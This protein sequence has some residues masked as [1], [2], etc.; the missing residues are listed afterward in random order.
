MVGA[1]D[2]TK[3][4]VGPGR[5]WLNVCA[6]APYTRLLINANGEPQQPAWAL[7][8]PWSAGQMIVDSNGN[9]QECVA[10][11]VGAGS[12][13]TWKTDLYGE[14]ADGGATWRCVALAP[15]YQFVGASEGAATASLSPK[16][17]GIPA[18][19]AGAPIDAYMQSEIEAIEIELK[20]SDLQKM[21]M[22]ITHGSYATGT[23]AGLPSGAQTYEEISFGGILTVPKPSVV[24]ISP[25]RDVI[26]KYVVIQL[27]R[28]F[29][30]DEIKLPYTRTKETMYK[31]KF[32]GLWDDFRPVG[33]KVGKIY[34]QL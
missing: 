32:E 10:T 3:I 12:A 27:Y 33:D 26:S 22:V 11:G 18:D 8:A 7:N 14:V 9:V 30:A 23:D 4:H 19:Q 31:V 15:V 1:I 34:R 20:E 16:N 6:P 25:R 17:V 29:Q 24:L 13:P 5:F 28:A 2:S 21:R